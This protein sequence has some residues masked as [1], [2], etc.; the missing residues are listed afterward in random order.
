MREAV[1]RSISARK[2]TLRCLMIHRFQ[3]VLV[4]PLLRVS[5]DREGLGSVMKRVK[6]ILI[7]ML[8]IIL[9]VGA[10]SARMALSPVNRD[11]TNP[12]L[13]TSVIGSTRLLVVSSG[14]MCQRLGNP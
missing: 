5:A 4:V 2:R 7:L 3:R 10:S 11:A 12:I 14:S 1:A 13:Q 8:T 9:G 6:P